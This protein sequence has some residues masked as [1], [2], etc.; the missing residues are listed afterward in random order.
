[1]ATVIHDLMI[2]D[3]LIRDLMEALAH[4]HATLVERSESPLGR[5][6]VKTADMTLDFD[7]SAEAKK[8]GESS[9]L[10]IKPTPFFGFSIGTST[11]KNTQQIQ[12]RNHAQLVLHIVNVAPTPKP[13][14]VSGDGDEKDNGRSDRETE[15]ER[16]EAV[17]NALHQIQ[18]F[19][20]SSSDIRAILGHQL[21]RIN[22]EFN[23]AQEELDSGGS[24][25]EAK[26]KVEPYYTEV[27]NIIMAQ[28]NIRSV[29][30]S[31]ETLD[32]WLEWQPE[33]DG[34]PGWQLRLQAPLAN[35]R[36]LVGGL[37]VPPT[38]KAQFT[39]RTKQVLA[40]ANENEA[41]SR[42]MAAVADLKHRTKDLSL[43]EDV[44]HTLDSIDLG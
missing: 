2:V 24:E 7:L 3:D 31:I 42:L 23:T 15:D 14:D 17:G 44:R 35:L 11:E 8:V 38:V 4:G 32:A 9:R 41:A 22:Q 12:V 16:R 25:A 34:V 28:D 40:S 26:Q 20:N 10:Q 18:Q 33:P 39:R 6:A 5:L 43:P 13:V 29:K 27:R 30:T 1:M 19:I 21:S 37:P 36:Q